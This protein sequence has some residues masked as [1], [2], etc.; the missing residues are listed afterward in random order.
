M[1]KFRGRELTKEIRDKSKEG[2]SSSGTRIKLRVSRAVEVPLNKETPKGKEVKETRI[3]VLDQ[4]E[5]EVLET[6]AIL[7]GM[8]PHIEAPI[9]VSMIS[10]M[11]PIYS[12][13]GSFSIVFVS[14]IPPPKA[15]HHSL[16]MQTPVR[17]LHDNL[18]NVFDANPTLPAIS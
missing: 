9:P 13:V 5:E 10:P 14:S 8:S 4:Q 15:Q 11:S 7:S 3:Q 12:D 6:S 17:S 18:E 2:A 16:A 1:R